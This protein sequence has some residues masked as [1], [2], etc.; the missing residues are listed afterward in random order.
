MLLLLS[1]CSPLSL[2][3]LWLYENELTKVPACLESLANLTEY[4][5]PSS[6]FFLTFFLKAFPLLQPAGGD[7]NLAREPPESE[8]VDL[9]LRSLLGA[10]SIQPRSLLQRAGQD[11]SFFGQSAKSASVKS[12]WAPLPF[13]ELLL[14]KA[15]FARKPTEGASSLSGKAHKAER[16]REAKKEIWRLILSLQT[17]SVEQSS[18]VP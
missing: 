10:H 8:R 15:L 17:L 14:L 1:L 18:E 12:C 4:S 3:R 11:S 16:V 6:L 2:T 9:S 13:A 5:C 7:P